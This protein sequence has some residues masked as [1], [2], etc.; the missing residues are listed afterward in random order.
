MHHICNTGD[1]FDM[2]THYYTKY[3]VTC[4]K[5]IAMTRKPTNKQQPTS[6]VRE[7]REGEER[8]KGRGRKEG[9]RKGIW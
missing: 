5:V 6:F 8:G 9:G 1:A 7:E 3:F 4:L 2:P